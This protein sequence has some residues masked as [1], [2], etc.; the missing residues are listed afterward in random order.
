MLSLTS[1]GLLLRL[2]IYGWGMKG[3]PTVPARHFAK[4]VIA[5]ILLSHFVRKRGTPW[6]WTKQKGIGLGKGTQH[7]KK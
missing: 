6:N 2:R 3:Q 5:C 7:P 1:F 4:G